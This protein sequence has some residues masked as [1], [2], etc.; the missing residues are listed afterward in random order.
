MTARDLSLQKILWN[1]V[2]IY[3]QTKIKFNNGILSGYTKFML[4]FI[5]NFQDKRL[6]YD[7]YNT[8]QHRIRET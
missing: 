7:I 6:F 3:N 8:K 2:A 1:L 5:A 4:K